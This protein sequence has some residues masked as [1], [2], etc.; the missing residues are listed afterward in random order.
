MTRGR[1]T[2]FGAIAIA[3]WSCYGVL[4]ASNKVTPPFMSMAV[5][6]TCATVTLLVW[7]LGRGEGFAGLF[8]VPVPTLLLGFLGLFGSNCLYPISLALGGQPVQVNMAS[9]SWPV[10]MAV[11]VVVFRVAKATWLDGLA[12]L[13]GFAGVVLLATKGGG[14]AIDWPVVPA[15]VGALCW[16]ALSALRNKVPPGPRD[17]MLHFVAVSGLACWLIVILFEGFTLPSLNEFL[18]LA[19]IGILPV[20]LA[21]YL[22]DRATRFGDPVLLAGMSFLEPVASTALI[23][24][25]LSQPVGWSD[26]AA[27]A[28]IL[29]AV[30]FS[31][32][33]ERLRRRHASLQSAALPS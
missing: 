27:L 28:L 24:I 8:P 10:F 33:S 22:W 18:R 20:G 4:L 12:M 17:V 19:A 2:L 1:G 32:M 9:L 16:A 30:S 23:A 3:A 5:V 25:V 14:L 15:F 13:I 11:F 29:L 26:A 31:V 7:R 6:F 21:N